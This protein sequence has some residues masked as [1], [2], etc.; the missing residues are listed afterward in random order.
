M[1]NLGH[2]TAGYAPEFSV[3][4]AATLP[5]MASWALGGPPETTCGQCTH[6]GYKT[7]RLDADGNLTGKHTYH[8]AR[9][10]QFKRLM[11]RGGPRLPAET[12]SCRC[13][14]PNPATK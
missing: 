9:C 1:Q 2:L 7:P 4:L 12:P 6:W 11:G 3:K 13:F 14:A 5:G 8:S 10:A